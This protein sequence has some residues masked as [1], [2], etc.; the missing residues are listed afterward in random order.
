MLPENVDEKNCGSG[1]K[2]L[3]NGKRKTQEYGKIAGVSQK[4]KTA[5]DKEN[6]EVKEKSGQ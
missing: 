4:K 6:Q 3:L 1:E 2:I 5:K